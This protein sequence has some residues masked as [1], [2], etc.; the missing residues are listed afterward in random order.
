MPVQFNLNWNK[1]RT[2]IN[3]LSDLNALK[4]EI[5]KV[6]NEVKSFDY[7]NLLSPTAKGR[8]KDFEGRYNKFMKT[9]GSAQRQ[10]DREFNKLLRQ[11]QKHRS[12]AEE[13][14]EYIK[15]L[16]DQQKSKIDKMAKNF[17]ASGK[18][19]TTRGGKKSSSKKTSSA[20]KSSAKKTARRKKATTSK[21]TKA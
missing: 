8:V 16:A 13:R 6:T 17:S 9:V 19:K 20:K 11:I 14:L 2:E 21:K 5:Q 12:T 10:L 7:Q 1:I 15:T 3:R 4:S 18:A